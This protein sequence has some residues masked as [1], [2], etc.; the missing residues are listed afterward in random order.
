MLSQ[1]N[2]GFFNIGSGIGT[3]IVDLAKIMIKI[4]DE[5]FEPE[6]QDSLKGDVKISQA[7]TTLAKIMISWEA[8]IELEQGLRKF[9]RQ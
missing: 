2:S 4:F 1:T 7:E 3:K 9:I 6:F 8:K 5:D